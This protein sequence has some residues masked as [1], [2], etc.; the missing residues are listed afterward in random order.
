[1]LFL[2]G[3]Q[4]L[5]GAGSGMQFPLVPAKSFNRFGRMKTPIPRPEQCVSPGPWARGVG[6]RTRPAGFG[7]GISA[8]DSQ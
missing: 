4:Q 3:A 5:L 1:M 7:A 8:Q 2:H 6:K